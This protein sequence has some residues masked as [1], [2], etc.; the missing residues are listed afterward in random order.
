[1]SEQVKMNNDGQERIFAVSLPE[2][3]RSKL[4]THR[5]QQTQP[6][7]AIPRKL[8]V[9]HPD[10]NRHQYDKQAVLGNVV[11]QSTVQV[12]L[13]TAWDAMIFIASIV[14]PCREFRLVGYK[15]ESPEG[16]LWLACGTGGH[17]Y[18]LESL[19]LEVSLLLKCASKSGAQQGLIQRGKGIFRGHC[20]KLDYGLDWTVDY[21]LC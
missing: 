2:H 5:K 14:N 4:A 7:T 3:L 6:I 11:A 8:S 15:S 13:L 17:N 19:Q 18:F 9:Y 21:E 20:K 1:M 12:L 10:A 16:V